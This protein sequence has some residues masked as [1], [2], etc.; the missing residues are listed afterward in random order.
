MNRLIPVVIRS[1]FKVAL[2]ASTC[3][4]LVSM[5]THGPKT[6]KVAE[7]DRIAK[8]EEFAY[9]RFGS[10]ALILPNIPKDYALC[11]KYDDTVNRSDQP[12]IFFVIKMDDDQIILEDSKPYGQVDWISTYQIQVKEY[13][14]TVRGEKLESRTPTSYIFDVKS[15]REIESIQDKK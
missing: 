10:K 2:T 4:I 11:I 7:F 13:P 3:I 12:L 8:F 6:S 9:S 15:G 14:G 5:C 1:G